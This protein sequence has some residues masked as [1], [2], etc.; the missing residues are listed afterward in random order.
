MFFLLIYGWFLFIALKILI[1]FNINK[2]TALMPLNIRIKLT[3]SL[4]FLNLAGLPP[5]SGFFVKLYVL[6][7]LVTD[8]SIFLGLILLFLSLVVLYAYTSVFYYYI[9]T[10]SSLRK[11][12]T[13]KL[14]KISLIRITISWS[15]LGLLFILFC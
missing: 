8:N 15:S 12:K 7:L 13:F 10:L 3:C 2:L 14:T 4:N 11:F 1:V 9:R 6:K 5:L